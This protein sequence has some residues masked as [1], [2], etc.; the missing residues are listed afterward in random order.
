MA[1][2]D[3][4]VGRQAVWNPGQKLLDRMKG[5]CWGVNPFLLSTRH[6]SQCCID[7]MEGVGAPPEAVAFSRLMLQKRDG[8]FCYMSSFKKISI[9]D[10]AELACPFRDNPQPE[11]VLL[12]GQPPIV[13]ISDMNN[14]SQINLLSEPEY[15]RMLGRHNEALLWPYAGGLVEVKKMP[16]GTGRYV[17]TFRLLNGCE[18]CPLAGIMTVGYDFNAAGRF[19]GV[20]LIKLVTAE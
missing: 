8:T 19:T 17:F 14:L 4:P 15:L 6:A 18:T 16:D 5:E 3:K 13:E 2:E 7:I 1:A 10:I 12:N 11:V 9:V 20:I